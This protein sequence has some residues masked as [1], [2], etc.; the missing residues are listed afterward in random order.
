MDYILFS[1][2]KW[3]AAQAADGEQGRLT[4]DG[5]VFQG[6][7]SSGFA[8]A[9]HDSTPS[10]PHQSP[11]VDNLSRDDWMLCIRELFGTTG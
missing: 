1:K 8:R 4:D 6:S 7:A 3:G 2:H 10:Q 9:T 5:I 11:S